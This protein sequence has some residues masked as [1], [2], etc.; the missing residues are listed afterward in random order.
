M[1]NIIKIFIVLIVIMINSLCYAESSDQNNG[2]PTETPQ[3]AKPDSD[4]SL[5]PDSVGLPEWF[6]KVL[7]AQFNGTFQFVNPF[8]NPYEGSNSFTFRNEKGEDTTHTYGLYFGTQLASTLQAYLDMDWFEGNG[9][10]NGVGMAGYVNGDVIRAGSADIP[11]VPYI[12]RFYLRYYYPLTEE[13]EKVERGM[14]QLAGEQPVSRLEFKAGKVSAADDFD[15]NRYANNN[16]TQFMNYDFL[17]NTAWD[18]AADTQ[19][20][21]YGLMSALVKPDWRFAMGI[22]AEP[23]KPNGMNFDGELGK[24]GYNF[25][26]S[27]KPNSCGTVVRFLSYLN[28]SRMGNFDD[29]IA[30]GI[31]TGMTP[32]LTAVEKS[33]GKRYGFGINVEQPIADKGETGLFARLGWSDGNDENWSY[34]ES[35]RHASLGAQV[36]GIRWGREDDRLGI[37]FGAN[38]LSVPHRDY[39]AAGGS[40]M[41]LGDGKLNYGYEQTIETYYSIH[42]WSHA[43]LS[44]DFQFIQNPGFNKDRGPVEVYGIRLHIAF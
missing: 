30:L 23:T 41:L 17:Y 19:G 31:K 15:Q 22:Y 44:P 8:H 39:L 5:I 21:T 1:A 12:A 29:A 38:G 34:V 36:S 9:V 16:R 42:V 11:K 27:V 37:A 4:T 10:S 25:E 32:D 20:Y 33:G 26:L 6:P 3:A 2:K 40:G 7:G 35:D 14:G 28:T 24:L 18:Y 43:A 13:M